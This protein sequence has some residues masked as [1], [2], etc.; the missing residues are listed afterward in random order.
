[1]N[2]SRL[3]S[4]DRREHIALYRTPIPAA[5]TFNLEV[6]SKEEISGN[7]RTKSVVPERI[8]CYNQLLTY[9]VL[10]QLLAPYNEEV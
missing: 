10:T 8:T 5:S 2:K 9:Y 4:P 7:Q 1:M 3:A 6:I